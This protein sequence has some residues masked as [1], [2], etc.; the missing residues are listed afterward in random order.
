[1]RRHST[2]GYQDTLQLTFCF[3]LELLQRLDAGLD[4]VVGLR[5]HADHHQPLGQRGEIL[6]VSGVRSKT[7]LDSQLLALGLV[8]GGASLGGLSRTGYLTSWKVSWNIDTFQFLSNEAVHCTVEHCLLAS[9]TEEH[10]HYHYRLNFVSESR[11][12]EDILGIK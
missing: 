1:M 3:I 9:L 2:R 6:E 8:H 10:Y 5:G 11:I 7:V 12:N 4:G